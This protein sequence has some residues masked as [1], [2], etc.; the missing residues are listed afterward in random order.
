LQTRHRVAEAAPGA[1]CYLRHMAK[2]RR[3]LRPA[4][5]GKNVT[6]SEARAAFREIGREQRAG[7]MK[8]TPSRQKT[9]A[10]AG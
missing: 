10:K 3:I 4:K 1:A 9:A 6:L 7:A 8:K 2:I 5:E